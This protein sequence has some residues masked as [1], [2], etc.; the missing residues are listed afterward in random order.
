MSVTVQLPPGCR[1]L[2]MQD[3]TR[4]TGREGGHVNVADEHAPHVR[5]EIGGDAGLVGHGSFRSFMGTKAGKWCI[6]CRFLAQ[7]WASC[8]PRCGGPVVP[9]SEMPAAPRSMMPS[10]CVVPIAP[11]G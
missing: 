2:R 4:Y 8:C 1:S 9:E 6:S 10:A 3:G 7:G 11:A 5:R